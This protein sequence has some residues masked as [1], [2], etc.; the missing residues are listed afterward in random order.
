MR[1][2][3]DVIEAAHT[4]F[5]KLFYQA[6]VSYRMKTKSLL[7]AVIYISKLG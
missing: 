2:K 3:S 5:E 7:H 4:G 1:L 6:L